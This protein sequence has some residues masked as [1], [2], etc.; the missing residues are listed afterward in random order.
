MTVYEF[1]NKYLQ[2]FHTK[3]AEIVPELCPYCHGGDKRDKRT[4]ALN[5][6]R[7]TFNCKRGSCGK[8]GHFTELCR[9]FGE[10]ADKD[11]KH[12][13]E[14]RKYRKPQVKAEPATDA[15][16]DYL[17]L[18]K[19]S[20]HAISAYKIGSDGGGNI[21]F[22]Y[23]DETGEHVFTKFRP[24]RKI[25]KGE[26]KAWREAGTK[27][28]LFGMH[29]CDFSKPLCI[30]EGEIDAMSCFEAGIANAVS[31][32]GGAE[33]FTWLDTC[34]EWVN[35]FSQI[36]L[37]G[38]NDAAGR[39]M[40]K[41]LSLKLSE[42]RVFQAE[43]ECKDANELLF[44]QGKE[45]VK[46][47]YD[48]A[49][50]IPVYGLIDLAGVTPL[51][52]SSIKSVGTSLKQL[53]K[54]LHGFA[55]GDVSVWT[56]RRGEGKSTLLS[57]LMLDAVEQGAKVC[58]Y[59]G[60]LSAERFQYWVDLQAAGK[61]NISS[62]FDN[63]YECETYYVPNETK[64]KIHAWYSQK[65]WLYDNKII[66]ESE[67][68]S[69]LKVFETAAKRYDCRVFLIDN[70]MTANNSVSNDS[71]LYRSQSNF[72]GKLVQFASKFDVH[73]HLVAHPRKTNGKTL[74]NDDVS[75]S[76]DITN[77]AA[78]VFSIEKLNAIEAEKE[79]FDTAIIIK[80]NRWHGSGG[81]SGLKYCAVSR[82]L[83]APSQGNTLKYGWEND[84]KNGENEEYNWAEITSMEEF[85]EDLPL[86]Y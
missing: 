81:F 43:H 11:F 68:S 51:E 23:C 79:G 50:E 35:K 47:A 69:I 60:E 6:D 20:E 24:A 56:G 63:A 59:S 52:V 29:L 62:Y 14:L 4:F 65:F 15:V 83:Y 22:P 64:Q 84:E 67:E 36:I 44:R 86:P 1:A 30:A 40:V 19:I 27:P 16:R 72:V 73:V 58:A 53:D 7:K 34:W 75:G 78:N 13:P 17:S 25:S 39:E 28:I 57:M 85:E 49:K 61:A 8:Q 31:V 55:Y 33:D 37:F 42:K 45:A 26:R 5:T 80:K 54:I 21:V 48:A 82:R 12:I 76:G 66:G 77:R 2:P 74:E 46:A 3:G 71:D 9:D 10:A 38:D 41:K 32:P 70:L 18:R